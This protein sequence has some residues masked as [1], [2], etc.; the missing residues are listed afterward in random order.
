MRA[1]R[2]TPTLWVL[3]I[4]TGVVSAPASR[5]HSSPVISPL[6]L[7]LWHP[8]K[9]GSSRADPSRGHTTV[10]P[11]RTGPS[12]TTS[13]PSPRMIVECP[14]LTPATS[15]IA[16]FGPEGRTPISMPNS[17]AR[18]PIHSPPQSGDAFHLLFC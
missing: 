12:P 1:S 6:P 10:T 5:I 11:V 2:T 15:V 9:T 3:V 16:S 18:I 7:N 8:A 17:R 14:T 4:P 13:G